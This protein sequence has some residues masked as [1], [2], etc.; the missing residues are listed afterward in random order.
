MSR[1]E[2]LERADVSQTAPATAD[3]PDVRERVELRR[4]CAVGGD[5]T[6]FGRTCSVFIVG[7]R[8]ALL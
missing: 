4:R 8:R 5:A 1:S 2:P 7:F 6:F 3:R